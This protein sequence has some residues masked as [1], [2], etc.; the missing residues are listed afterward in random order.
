M[1]SRRAF[2]GCAPCAAVALMAM[3]VAAQTGGVNR[4]M[5][6]TGDYRATARPPS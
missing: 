4:T 6:G 1:R 5:L 3:R 2:M